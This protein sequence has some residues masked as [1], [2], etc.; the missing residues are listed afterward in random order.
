LPS[1]G[2]A[3]PDGAG[4]DH[5]QPDG[6][7]IVPVFD[8]I[9]QPLSRGHR[10][11]GRPVRPKWQDSRYEKEL[12]KQMFAHICDR[13]SIPRVIAESGF[14]NAQL[15]NCPANYVHLINN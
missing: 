8:A 9:V 12:Y 5:G 2:E 7:E 6:T 14:G 10:A 11:H 15:L 4:L 13:R 3:N 1:L